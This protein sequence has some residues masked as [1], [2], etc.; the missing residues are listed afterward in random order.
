MELPPLSDTQ[1]KTYREAFSRFDNSVKKRF[2]RPVDSQQLNTLEYQF[3]PL[4]KEYEDLQLY[5][6][7]LTNFAL[8]NHLTLE[9]CPI[10]EQK[11]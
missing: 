7:T 8:I 4:V 10:S 6:L 9:A 1:I 5:S 11:V 3:N 2:R